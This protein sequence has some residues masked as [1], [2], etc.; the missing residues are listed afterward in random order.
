[1]AATVAMPVPYNSSHRFCSDSQK[2]ASRWLS[3]WYI[4]VMSKPAENTVFLTAPQ[5]EEQ[6]NKKALDSTG[7]PLPYQ[8][9]GSMQG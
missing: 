9:G 6:H 3:G 5:Q 7:D 8:P 4:S 2:F 1:M